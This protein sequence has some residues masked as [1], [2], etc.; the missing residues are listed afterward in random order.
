MEDSEPTEILKY[1][2]SFSNGDVFYC[3][4]FEKWNDDDVITLYG[5]YSG[6]LYNLES[7]APTT[8]HSVMDYTYYELQGKSR[9]VPE[10]WKA[11]EKPIKELSGEK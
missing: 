6:T 1:K 10:Y 7:V 3:N 11:L 9:V 4:R 8:V 5:A 2:F